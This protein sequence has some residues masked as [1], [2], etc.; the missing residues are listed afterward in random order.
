MLSEN[1]TKLIRSLVQKKYRH[2]H[3]NF[4]AEGRK[5]ILDMLSAGFDAVDHIYVSQD[6]LNEHHRILSKVRGKLTILTEKEF[7]KISNL[8]SAPDMIL[9]GQIPAPINPLSLDFNLGLHLYLDRVQDPGNVGTILRTAEW[10]G[11]ATI[12]ISEGTADIAHPKV[13]QAS[14]GSFSRL[15]HWTGSL[16]NLKISDGVEVLGA[17]LS[18]TSIYATRLPEQGILVIG[19]EGQGISPDL[20]S[21][22]KKYVHIPAYSP[23]IE[24]LNAA[25]ASA[26]ILAEWRRQIESK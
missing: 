13:V 17:S 26:I 9:I 14:M 4:L 11:V 2:K 10:F 3:N 1:T 15:P 8:D 7:G 22:I 21:M 19:S 25:N 24:S 12:G 18:G 5:T 20:K 23:H 6:A 16:A